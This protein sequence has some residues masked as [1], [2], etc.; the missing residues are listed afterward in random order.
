MKTALLSSLAVSMLGIFFGS[1]PMVA[2]SASTQESTV[3]S[4]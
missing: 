4:S 1:L 3:I 2:Q